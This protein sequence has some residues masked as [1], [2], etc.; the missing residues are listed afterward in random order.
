VFLMYGWG[1]TTRV[2]IYD[3]GDTADVPNVRL[4]ST[5]TTQCS[6]VRISVLP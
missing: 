3:Q 6:L 2:P 1:G 5:T 4:D